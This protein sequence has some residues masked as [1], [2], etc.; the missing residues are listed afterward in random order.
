[1]PGELGFVMG[2]SYFLNQIENRKWLNKPRKLTDS[3]EVN[4]LS[5]P[6]LDYKCEPATNTVSQGAVLLSDNLF[7]FLAET[8]FSLILMLCI[9]YSTV[10]VRLF[11]A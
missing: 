9:V 1:M 8:E 7:C 11:H 2:Q 5:V 4:K 10:P 6:S 3:I